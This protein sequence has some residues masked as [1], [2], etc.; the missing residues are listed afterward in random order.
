MMSIFSPFSSS[1]ILRMRDPRT[2][3]QAPMG[4]TFE[5]FDSSTETLDLKRRLPAGEVT[6]YGNLPPTRTRFDLDWQTTEGGARV[7]IVRFN[8]W[9]M[10]DLGTWPHAEGLSSDHFFSTA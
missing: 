1:T 5:S 10:Q 9:L 2:P 6:S 8:I 3:T 7:G 4:S